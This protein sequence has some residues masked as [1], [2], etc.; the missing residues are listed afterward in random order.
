MAGTLTVQTL[1]GPSSGAN[2]NKLLIPSGQTL[3]V[4]GGTLVPSAGQILQVVEDHF[5]TSS[6]F[7][8]TS[9]T[10]VDTGHLISITPKSDSSK[11]IITFN[12]S[13]QSA[14]TD[15]IEFAI[16]KD[17]S[18]IASS[19]Y[20]NWTGGASSITDTGTVKYVDDNTSTTTR[21]YKLYV[22]ASF[23]NTVY[24]PHN[25]TYFVSTLMEIAQ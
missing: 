21:A 16:Y 8:T 9:S 10:L 18:P 6:H 1:Q 3:D 22:R 15:R 11:I 12:L 17:A 13:T 4:S 19:V 14:S 5:V 24:A 25:Q 2:A 23:G 7:S 20:G